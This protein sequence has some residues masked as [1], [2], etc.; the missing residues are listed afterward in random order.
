[1]GVVSPTLG[2][3]PVLR[4]F[5]SAA[6]LREYVRE[7]DRI[8]AELDRRSP[9]LGSAQHPPPPSPPPPGMPRGEPVESSVQDVVHRHGVVKVVGQVAVVLRENH[10]FSVSLGDPLRLIAAEDLGSSYDGLLVSG[11][12]IV[13]VARSSVALVRLDSAGSLTR[14]G[15]WE[16]ATHW[17]SRDES[18][19]RMVDGKLVLFTS[20]PLRDRRGE[21]PGF[22]MVRRSGRDSHWIPLADSSSLYR[23]GGAVTAE[24][25]PTVHSLVVCDPATGELR[26]R[27]TSVLGA[28]ADA[29]DVS[30]RAAY[31]WIKP[32]NTRGPSRPA[33]VYRIPLDG[34]PPAAVQVSH[35][36]AHAT[37]FEEREDGTLLQ[38]V[39]SD[40]RAGV[41]TISPR[42]WGDGSRSIPAERYRW[43]PGSWPDLMARFRAG[44]LFVVRR[45]SAED[46]LFMTG[47]EGDTTLRRV[48]AGVVYALD[49]SSAD[50]AVATRRAGTGASFA[51]V[52]A[53]GEG[54]DS[55]VV[56]E[57]IP[58]V[59]Q[60]T[61]AFG[62]WVGLSTSRGSDAALTVLWRDGE[63]L[64]EGGTIPGRSLSPQCENCWRPAPVRPFSASGRLY[65]LLGDSVM[66]LGRQGDRLTVLNR[67][68]LAPPPSEVGGRW[69]YT[70]TTSSIPEG[71]S[72]RAQGTYDMVQRGDRLEV[73]FR[74][75]GS[76]TT[77]G[78]ERATDGSGQGSGRVI[79]RVIVLDFQ[80]C[81]ARGMLMPAGGLDGTV[82]CTSEGRRTVSGTWSAQR[83]ADGPP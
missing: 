77:N 80:G 60:G 17:R 25:P 75:A 1:M 46:G 22:P 33:L 18:P 41:L 52:S 68:H 40:G 54:R 39:G 51:V 38:L 2:Q 27:A 6:E 66:A 3:Q 26:C 59:F 35:L 76:C 15:A 74:Q 47:I 42:D 43:L 14:L 36:P 45:G 28:P 83:Q 78:V 5:G 69:T 29:Y 24:D 13:A 65:T 9:P 56:P 23:P 7:M 12:V 50:T 64:E 61:S 62:P 21:P 48:S 30:T 57:R 70:E 58:M 34:G 32:Y 44:R 79:G 11:R 16:F 49:F 20:L 67:V 82:E 55:L 72:C 71:E 63:D 37:A 31:V 53:A 4:P 19:F 8:Q 10:L 81:V 73:R